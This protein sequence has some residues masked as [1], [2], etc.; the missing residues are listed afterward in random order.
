HR[1]QRTADIPGHSS[2]GAIHVMVDEPSAPGLTKSIAAQNH[3]RCA[4]CPKPTARAYPTWLGNDPVGH[5]LCQYGPMGAAVPSQS[6]S[7]RGRRVAWESFGQGPP[8]VFLHGT[9]WSS[10]LWRPIA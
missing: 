5:P 8:L 7:W 9:P 2:A 4:D 3:P 10:A 1:D 6:L